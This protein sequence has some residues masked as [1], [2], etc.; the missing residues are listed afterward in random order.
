[1][2]DRK[3]KMSELIDFLKQVKETPRP[4]RSMGGDSEVFELPDNPCKY[5][6]NFNTHGELIAACWPNSIRGYLFKSL[7]YDDLRLD[8]Y[9]DSIVKDAEGKEKSA[10]HSEWYGYLSQ[11]SLNRAEYKLT[12]E[13][14]TETIKICL[15]DGSNITIRTD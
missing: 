14:R 11:R 1:M 4:K 3:L 10:G 5:T 13:G 15:V 8:L 6:A 2:V 7:D 9:M 12:N